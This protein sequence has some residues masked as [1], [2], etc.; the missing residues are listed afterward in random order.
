[1]GKY[2]GERRKSDEEGRKEGRWGKEVEDGAEGRKGR[3]GGR[4]DAGGRDLYQYNT[5]RQ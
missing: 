1:M 4:K 2:G 3:E 5:L